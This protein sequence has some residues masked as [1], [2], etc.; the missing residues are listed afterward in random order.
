MAGTSSIYRFIMDAHVSVY[1]W[2]GGKLG[3]KLGPY[4]ILLLTTT[5]RRSGQE[6]TSPLGYFKDGENFVITASNGGGPNH[7]GWYFNLV[8]HPQALIEVGKQKITVIAKQADPEEKKRLWALLISLTPRYDGYQKR[9]SRDI[10]M[11]ILHPK[12]LES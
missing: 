11:M 6:R 3:G 10:P 4:D 2:T 9:T 1:R 12:D 8:E 7:P 5:G